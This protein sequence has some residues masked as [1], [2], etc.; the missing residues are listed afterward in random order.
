MGLILCA[1]LDLIAI[2]PSPFHI[3]VINQRW[4]SHLLTLVTWH[5]R[6]FDTIMNYA[7]CKIGFIKC[8]IYENP[9]SPKALKS[10]GLMIRLWWF[11]CRNHIYNETFPS[12]YSFMIACPKSIV[13]IIWLWWLFFSKNDIYNETFPSQDLLM[14]AC[15]QV[16]PIRGLYFTSRKS[17][18]VYLSA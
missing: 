16:S 18:D 15:I 6:G 2:F 17:W 13:M 3:I 4:A 1:T 11:F 9:L 5:S 12:H 10:K 14:I 7:W 8:T